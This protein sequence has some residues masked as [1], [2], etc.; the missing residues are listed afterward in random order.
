MVILIKA[1]NLWN[2]VVSCSSCNRRKNDRLADTKYLSLL[3]ERNRKI[4]A[5]N[6]TLLGDSYREPELMDIYRWA[7]LN[8]YESMWE[9]K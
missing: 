9:P 2:L 7:Q 1:D 8:G 6:K 3:I 4:I 5:F